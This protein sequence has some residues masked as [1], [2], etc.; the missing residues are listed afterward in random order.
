MEKAK[1]GSCEL[2]KRIGPLDQPFP[3]ADPAFG[4]LSQ[5]C[6]SLLLPSNQFDLNFLFLDLVVQ[7]FSARGWQPC[8]A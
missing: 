4:R 2:G 3:D 5:N 1:R 7:L 8:W 6:P